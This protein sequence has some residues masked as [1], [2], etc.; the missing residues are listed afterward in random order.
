MEMPWHVL[1]HHQGLHMSTASEIR[2]YP[3][4]QQLIVR[5]SLTLAGWPE[6]HRSEIV[7]LIGNSYR[8][9]G[10]MG[11]RTCPRCAQ[12][13]RLAEL[14]TTPEAIRRVMARAGLAPMPP[15][16]PLPRVRGQLALGL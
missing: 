15:P 3:V 12:P 10:V 13:L 4:K 7:Q 1:S 8:R 9:K 16:P 14:A 6:V 2:G 11:K 5:G